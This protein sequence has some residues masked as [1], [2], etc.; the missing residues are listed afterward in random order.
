M[1]II[2]KLSWISK[3]VCFVC[4]RIRSAPN[5]VLDLCTKLRLWLY[6]LVPKITFNKQALCVDC[7]VKVQ[8]ASSLQK[9]ENIIKTIIGINAH[10]EDLRTSFSSAKFYH[11]RNNKWKWTDYCCG[12][13]L[14]LEIHVIVVLAL[15]PLVILLELLI[16]KII[17]F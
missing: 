9:D 15:K 10:N 3:P 8:A 11:W 4:L 12:R 5:T 13:N 17:P 2:T 1:C 7:D 16:Y 6:H 14:I